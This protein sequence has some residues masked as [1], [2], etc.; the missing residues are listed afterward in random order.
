M[1][2]RGAPSFRGMAIPHP[3]RALRGRQSGASDGW[4]SL[5]R[6][7]SWHRRLVAAACAAVAATAGLQVLRPAAPP[8]SPVVV[9]ATGLAGGRL[10]TAADLA[11]R[12]AA[13]DSVPDGAYADLQSLVGRRLAAPLG[14]GEVVTGRRLV[15][16]TL[17]ADFTGELGPGAVE[18]PVRITDPGPL[19]LLR[20]GD[21]VD[22]I[23]V[24]AG[25]ASGGPDTDS[26]DAG[27]AGAGGATTV[28]GAGRARVVVA[29]APVLVVEPTS[30]ADGDSGLLSADTGG[31]GAATGA[32]L[33]VL[34][35]TPQAALD[36]AGTAVGSVVSV[37]V[38]PAADPPSRD[39]S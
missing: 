4:R 3:A 11:V 14:T 13:P 36:L 7:V 6:A 31:D 5:V 12:A 26:A 9:A 39:G 21:R 20:P 29:R 22:V 19:V 30:P 28:A 33:V 2:Q 37:V 16:P 38:H 8:T 18:T 27:G 32:G 24:P 35:T 10:L 1:T 15:G 34:A 25:T 23:A 17:L